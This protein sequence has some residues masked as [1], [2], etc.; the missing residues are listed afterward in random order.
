MLAVAYSPDVVLGLAPTQRGY[1]SDR[2]GRFGSEL[3]FPPEDLQVLLFIFL[4]CQY[5]E[6]GEEN[7]TV[8]I[9]HGRCGFAF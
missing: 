2:D 7:R 9:G 3:N 1:E 5:T 8:F 6:G 4:C